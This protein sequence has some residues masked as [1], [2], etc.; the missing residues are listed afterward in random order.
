MLNPNASKEGVDKLAYYESKFGVERTKGMLEN[1]KNLFQ[2]R[3]Y[4]FKAGGKT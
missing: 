2:E 1:M 3:G 4:D